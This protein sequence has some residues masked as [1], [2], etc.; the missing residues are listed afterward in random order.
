MMVISKKLEEKRIN[1]YAMN[2]DL[3]QTI[4]IIIVFTTYLQKLKKK[5]SK[6]KPE[7]LGQATRILGVGPT[8]VSM[9]LVWVS[10]KIGGFF[11]D[12]PM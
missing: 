1:Y 5:L 4:L 2:L 10:T 3:F 7:T 11:K 6:I 8:D 9:L 12:Q